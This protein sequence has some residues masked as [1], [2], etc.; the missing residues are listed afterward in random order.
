MN[1]MGG[2]GA[3]GTTHSILTYPAQLERR[4]QELVLQTIQGY[5]ANLGDTAAEENWDY[6]QFQVRELPTSHVLDS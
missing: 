2:A 5:G 6:T 4:V 1:S 3:V